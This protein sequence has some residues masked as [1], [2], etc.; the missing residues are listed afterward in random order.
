MQRIEL[1]KIVPGMQ[2]VLSKSKRRG[3]AFLMVPY[4]GSLTHTN[5]I[6]GMPCLLRNKPWPSTTK[7]QSKAGI[8]PMPSQE[9][10]AEIPR[11]ATLLHS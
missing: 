7:P 5:G 4:V 3:D 10:A 11:C 6:E 9:R 2:C 8:L 1:G